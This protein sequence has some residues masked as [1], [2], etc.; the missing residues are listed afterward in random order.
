MLRE[1]KMIMFFSSSFGNA[2]SRMVSTTSVIIS[3]DFLISRLPKRVASRY[4]FTYGI[5]LLTGTDTS[6]SSLDSV[7]VP[8]SETPESMIG[9]PSCSDGA[10]SDDGRSTLSSASRSQ[11]A[12]RLCRK[13]SRSEASALS[14][15]GS[16][17]SSSSSSSSSPS[18]SSFSRARVC[19]LIFASRLASASRFAVSTANRS[20]SL[21]ASCSARSRSSLAFSSASF[22]RASKMR[23]TVLRTLS[24]F[25]R[26]SVLPSKNSERAIQYSTAMTSSYNS[27]PCL[28][29]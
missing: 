7:G 5:G 23:D 24:S 26:I 25:T 17:L 4:R 29:S 18:S 20:R 14:P 19:S 12:M 11:L 22:S 10:S 1:D 27:G 13:A 21:A 8:P 9:S 3:L 15:D 6:A 16:S 28:I 2:F